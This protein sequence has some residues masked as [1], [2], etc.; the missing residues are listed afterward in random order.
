MCNHFFHWYGIFFA[1]PACCVLSLAEKYTSEKGM[2]LSLFPVVFSAASQPD[3]VTP[4]FGLLLGP[5]APISP[6]SLLLS[7]CNSYSPSFWLISSQCPYI[8]AMTSPLCFVVSVFQHFLLPCV[9]LSS[10]LCLNSSFLPQQC[11]VIGS[12]S[13]TAMELIENREEYLEDLQLS[14]DAQIR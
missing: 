2:E 6:K 13:L 14:G 5:V 7:L 4:S 10:C 3:S 11:F 12:W 1:F 9:C 8:T